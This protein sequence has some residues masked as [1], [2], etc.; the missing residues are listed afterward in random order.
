MR[1]R[2]LGPVE[3]WNNADRVE[4][5]GSKLRTFL[6]ALVLAHGRVVSDQTLVE[7]LW[8]DAPPATAQAQIQTYASRLRGLLGDGAVVDRHRPGYRLHIERDDVDLT[9]FEGLAAEG[10]AALAERRVEAAA[11]S[12]AGALALWRGEALTG[13]T[14]FLADLERPRLEE[15]RLAV[16]EDRV[17]ADLALGRHAGLVPELTAVVTAHPLRERPRAQL[18]LALYRCGRNADALAS[19]QDY[20]RF[21]AEELGIDPSAELQDLHQAILSDRHTLLAPSASASRPVAAPPVTPLQAPPADFTGRDAAVDR[22]RALLGDTG[23]PRVCAITGMGGVGKTALALRV[24]QQVAGAYPDGQ[25]HVDLQGSSRPLEAAEA[26]ARLLRTLGAPD[27]DLP[28]G[29]EELTQCYRD[30]LAGR[31]VLIVLD[32]AAGERQIRPLLPG[33]PGCGVLL[34]GRTRLAALEGADRISLQPFEPAEAV[35]LLA[36]HTSPER[37]AAEPRALALIAERCGYLPLAIRACGARLV[38]HPHWPLSRLADRLADPH[39]LLDELRVA[40]LDVQAALALSYRRLPADLRRALRLL[41]L[42]ST[43]TFSL[44]IAAVLLDRPLTET[45]AQVE[46]LVEAYL[47]EVPGGRPDTYRFHRLVH[48]V[49]RERALTEETPR[50]R[51]AAIRRVDLALTA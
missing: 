14:D 44:W 2:I 41:S 12:L 10:R 21:L 16:L 27:G 15:A 20:R 6:T 32:D 48:A 8:E 33:V 1:V 19:F 22:A 26:L 50:L 49:A 38:G 24:A 13:V 39:W 45:R 51:A 37:A 35:A 11:R 4:L 43:P 17:E 36:R 47:L 31:R 29:A 34:T 25:V 40:D 42:L 46:E 9:R 3:L 28:R 30:R 5:R 18:M 23:A 7:M